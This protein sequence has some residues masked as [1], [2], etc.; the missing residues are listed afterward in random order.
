MDEI[1][2]KDREH[3]DSYQG[4]T[5]TDYIQS[6]YGIERVQEAFVLMVNAKHVAGTHHI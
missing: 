1:D 3:V 4:Q 6:V 2:L 5:L